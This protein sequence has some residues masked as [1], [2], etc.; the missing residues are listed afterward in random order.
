MCDPLGQTRR[1]IARPG[2]DAD[3]GAGLPAAR[4]RTTVVSARNSGRAL[5]ICFAV[6]MSGVPVALWTGDR[7]EARRKAD[8]LVAHA[9]G[10]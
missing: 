3:L 4:S 5:P 9:V 2:G 7:G 8:L 1:H 6:A 10:N